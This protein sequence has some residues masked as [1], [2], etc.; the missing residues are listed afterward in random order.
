VT[1]AGV[2]LFLSLSAWQFQR[3]Q[4]KERWLAQFDDGSAPIMTLSPALSAPP[5]RT[6]Q[7]ARAVGRYDGTRQLLQDGQSRG[8]RPGYHVWTVLRLAGGGMA[9]VNRGWIPQ[10]FDPEKDN[11]AAPDGEITATGWWRDL[12]EPG[13][14][15]DAGECRKPAAFP[16]VVVYP[17]LEQLVCVL[18]EPVLPGLL[19]LD[20]LEPGGFVRQWAVASL[21]PERHYGYAVTWFALGLAAV[22]L[23]VTLNLKRP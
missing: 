6:L 16:A 7:R 9:L 8:G 20:P 4:A 10:P 14:R 22:I 2:V 5:P 21:P 18:G 17:R 15:L 12:P 23:F 13:I 11:L 19:L 1:G 3:G